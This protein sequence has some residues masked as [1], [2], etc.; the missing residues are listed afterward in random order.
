MN[1]WIFIVLIV[2]NIQHYWII[3]TAGPPLKEC[4]AATTNQPHFAH[5]PHVL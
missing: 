2:Q 5:F 1:I 4:I 3:A